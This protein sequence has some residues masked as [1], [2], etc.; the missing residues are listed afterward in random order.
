ML[1]SL[2]F[3]ILGFFF[4]AYI[5]KTNAIAASKQAKAILAE[6]QKE[7]DVMRREAKVQAKDAVLRAR[8]NSGREFTAQRKD[9]LDLEKRVVEREKNLTGKLDMLS[10]KE[11]QLAGRLTE[12]ADHKESLIDKQKKLDNL[13]AEEVRR[14]EEVADLSKEDARK[15]IMK[16]ME[17]ELQGEV[18]SLIRHTQKAAKETA[19][20]KAREIIATSIQRY[21]AET[22]CDI[23]TSSV[24]LASDD[25]KGRIIGK[26]GRNIKSFEAETGVNVLIDET[27]E[28]VV[29]SCYDPIRREIARVSLERLIEDGRIHPARI[30]ETVAKVKQEI[31]D[32]IRSAGEDALFGLGITGVA[33]ELMHTL[34]KLKFRTSYKQNVLDHSIETAHIMGTMA[35]E[36]GLDPKIAKR[37]GIFHDIGKAVDHEVEGGHAV[38]GANLMRKYGE[39]RIVYNAVGAH[40]ED[41][42]RE[43]VYAVICDACDA[44]TAARPGARA[45]ATDLYLHRLDQIEKIC[46]QYAGVKSS[47][48]V[49]AGREVR[50]MVEP[51]KF[52]DHGA[53]LLAKNIA[54][55]ITKEVKIPGVVRVTVIRET[56]CVEYAK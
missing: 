50:I 5:T 38:I 16:R 21:A 39:D 26:E 44:L 41:M 49:Q 22:V 29:L 13:V 30:E 2:G 51:L 9:I 28:V 45:E 4:H 40:H 27:P 24:S 14:V 47:Y 36:M 1:L 3:L 42:E 55:E 46:N 34:G 12:V 20:K 37:I 23:T 35:A 6:A 52:N 7:A 48:A 56:R 25:I 31:D 8:D 17:D 54:S 43:S 53:S 11:M 33:P 10:S 15:T 19:K 18:N 32:T